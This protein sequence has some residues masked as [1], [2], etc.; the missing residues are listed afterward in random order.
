MMDQMFMKSLEEAVKKYRS[1]TARTT[2][3]QA[4]EDF[5]HLQSIAEKLL[6]S[7][8]AGDVAQAKTYTLA[9]SRQ[10]SDSFSRQPPEFKPLAQL[11][12]RV[13]KEIG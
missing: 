9:F 6:S 12:A 1:A 8:R 4:N 10:A 3:T 2:D 7:L 13:R 11:I 5:F